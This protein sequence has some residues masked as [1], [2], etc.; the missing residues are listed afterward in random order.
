MPFVFLLG[1]CGLLQAAQFGDFTYTDYGSYVAITD[2]PTTAAGAVIIPPTINGKPVK[3]IANGAFSY[4]SSLTGVTLPSSVTSI[5]SEAFSYCSNLATINFPAGLTT[6]GRNAFFYCN[7]ITTVTLPSSLTTLGESAFSRC[8]GLMSISVSPSN[9]VF[10]TVGG[11]LFNKSKT[12]LLQYPGAKSGPYIVPATVTEI[13]SEA[14]FNADNLT[15]VLVSHGLT[16]IG[17]DGFYGCSSLKQITLPST[18]TS[19]GDRAFSYSGL[20][21][22][23]L[24]SSVTSI[25]IRAY[26]NCYSLALAHI[27][28]NVSGLGVSV[29]AECSS[30]A[31]ISVSPANPH[32]MEK[33][34]VVFDKSGT[35][36]IQFPCGR[37]GHYAVPYGVTSI[38]GSAFSGSRSL[39]SVSLPVGLSSIGDSSF[40][41]CTS[42]TSVQLPVGLTT[43]GSSAFWSCWGLADITIPASVT[44]VK[45]YAFYGCRALARVTFRGD[46]PVMGSTVFTSTPSTFEIRYYQNRTG[47]TTPEWQSFKMVNLGNLSEIP[48]EI[49]VHP[50]SGADLASGWSSENFGS[51]VSG[52]SVVRTFTIRNAGEV[53][54]TALAAACEGSHAADFILGPLGA[55]TVPPG[56]STTINV[57]FQAT[58][59][60][61]KE[62]FLRIFSNDADENPFEIALIGNVRIPVPEI[63]VMQPVGSS[64]VDG[65][66][67]RSFGT[68]KIGTKGI[69]KT[70]TI[71]NTGTANL[72]G[73]S[74]RKEGSH[75]ADFIVGALAKTTLA[76]GGS[77]TFNVTFKAQARGTRTAA[78][79]IKS[80]DADE[81]P[82]NIKLA[83]MGVLP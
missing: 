26:A 35:T 23:T 62:A 15:D 4:C 27:S 9:P 50:W 13:G 31:A 74:I 48:A 16:K 17:N 72:T 70:F 77:M 28:E 25:G 64:L 30:L 61:D 78:I 63:V 18:L 65:T 32:Y 6:I 76:A 57:T 40:M 75:K 51:L 54:L 73:L 43:I 24:P 37:G 47:F 82:F 10:V 66:A 36:L 2:Y 38:A 19:V 83:G 29:F 53:P 39:A 81:N 69:T 58:A 71:K 41:L 22:A 49:V 33:D 11:V 20:T 7:S 80:N 14:F 79:L 52:E 55:A 46:A 67:R 44:A 68:V 60:G 3:N 34:G 5:D 12:K 21:A 45:F 8:S 42:L 1:L 56:S 59:G